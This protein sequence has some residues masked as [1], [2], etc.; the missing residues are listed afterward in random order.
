MF[1]RLALTSVSVLLFVL[2]HVS[3]MSVAS[4][5]RVDADRDQIIQEILAADSDDGLEIGERLKEELA[6]RLHAQMSKKSVDQQQQQQQQLA[7]SESEIEFCSECIRTSSK[8][9]LCA[10]CYQKYLYKASSKR[11]KP[12]SKYWYSRAG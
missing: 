4:E 5:S 12:S 10:L 11:V 6:S 9:V 8:S 7:A 1:S 2:S 3:T